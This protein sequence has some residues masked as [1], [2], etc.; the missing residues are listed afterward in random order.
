MSDAISG[1]LPTYARINTGSELQPLRETAPSAIEIRLLEQGEEEEA[2]RFVKACPEGTFFHLS[3][4]K[5]IM[6]TIL[7][8]RCFWLTARR[9]GGVCGIFPISQVRNR[10]FGDCMVSLPLAV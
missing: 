1:D 7:K 4:W 2:D 6:E 8:R 10:L 3:G 5:T 9:E